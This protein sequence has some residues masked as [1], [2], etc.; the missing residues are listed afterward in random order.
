MANEEAVYFEII[1]SKFY[2]LEERTEN[3][4]SKK[5]DSIEIHSWVFQDEKEAIMKLNDLIAKEDVDLEK[6]LDNSIEFLSSK[7]N[8]QEVEIKKD[9]YNMKAISWLKIAFVGM[10]KRKKG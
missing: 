6:D 1:G 9:K 3:E 4:N 2:I 5:K 10:A 7:Y 8:L